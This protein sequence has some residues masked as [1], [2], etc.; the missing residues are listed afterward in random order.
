MLTSRW[1]TASLVLVVI[2]VVGLAACSSGGGTSTA[3]TSATSAAAAPEQPAPAADV[4]MGLRK[5]DQIAKQIA[6]AAGTDKARAVSLDGQIEPIW[7]QIEDTVKQNDQD[8]YLAMEDNFAVLEKAADEGNA[9]EAAKGSAGITSAV[10]P[11]LAK[12]S[13]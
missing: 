5:I 9:A 1:R 3:P 10:Q 11:Y 6:E 4:A 8:T 13:G 7:K 2:S 12:Y